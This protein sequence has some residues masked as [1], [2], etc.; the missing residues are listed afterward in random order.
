MEVLEQDV[1]ARAAVV[2]GL[3]AGQVRAGRVGQ[4]GKGSPISVLGGVIHASDHVTQV[5]AIAAP[6]DYPVL[7]Q[8]VF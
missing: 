4:Q 7:L 6:H 3:V 1:L 5:V 8:F 2:L